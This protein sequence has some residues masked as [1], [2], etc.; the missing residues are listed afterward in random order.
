VNRILDLIQAQV[1]LSTC[2]K[3]SSRFISRKTACWRSYPRTNL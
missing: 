3:S 1:P 2:T